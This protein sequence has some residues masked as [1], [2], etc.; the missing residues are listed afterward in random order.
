MLLFNL[1]ICSSVSL[2]ADITPKLIAMGYPAEQFEGFM[3]R[4]NIDEV[5]RCVAERF[6]SILF[7]SI[8]FSSLV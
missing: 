4:N 3:I 8:L 6:S 1:H 7:Y 2:R 5:V